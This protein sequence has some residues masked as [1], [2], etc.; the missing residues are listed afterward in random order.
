MEFLIEQDDTGRWRWR[1]IGRK[2][3]TLLRSDET[4]ASRGEAAEAA[5]L[6]SRTIE[7][8]SRRMAGAVPPPRR[9][10]RPVPRR[11]IFAPH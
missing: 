10:P 9:P 4:F 2:N 8:A 11:P 1:L 6:W 7:G 3:E 5:S